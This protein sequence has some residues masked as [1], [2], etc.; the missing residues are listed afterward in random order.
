MDQKKR[1]LEEGVV[2]SAVVTAVP[3]PA[4]EVTKEDVKKLVEPFTKEQ[5]MDLLEDAALLH[6]GS[7]SLHVSFVYE[8]IQAMIL[9][10]QGITALCL[11]V[12]SLLCKVG[13]MQCSE[14][15]AL[16]DLSF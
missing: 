4:F 7:F 10:W 12:Q 14:A 8:D 9:C 2:P 13:S 15:L 11:V 6:A 16:G 3:V 1:K 5:L